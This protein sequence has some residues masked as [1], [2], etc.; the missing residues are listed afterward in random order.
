[1]NKPGLRSVMVALFISGATL[2]GCDGDD[3]D[4]STVIPAVPTNT[5][6]AGSPTTAPPVNTATPTAAPTDPPAST[7]TAAPTDPPASTPTPGA[8]D[9]PTSPPANTATPTEVPSEPPATATATATPGEVSGDDLDIIESLVTGVLPIAQSLAEFGNVAGGGAAGGGGGIGPRIPVPPVTTDCPISGQLTFSCTP[10]GAGST[11]D[12]NFAQCELGGSGAPTTLIDGD[13]MQ[14]TPAAC[15]SPI[16]AG[17]LIEITFDGSVST[18][19]TANGQPVDVTFTM[20]TTVVNQADGSTEVTLDG[21]VTES[22]VGSATLETL[23]TIVVPGS[24]SCP[25]AGQ[26]RVTVGGTPSLITN[27]PNGSV[28]IDL[29]DNGSVDRSLASCDAGDIQTCP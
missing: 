9:T 8:Q 28:D 4:S 2:A 1:M 24:D 23:Q 19:N 21:T 12:V 20:T 3:S 25:T 10:G 16:P 27:N 17:A 13:F 11:I 6:V 29:G 22:C 14:I 7:P 18:T 15:F 26:L 5:A